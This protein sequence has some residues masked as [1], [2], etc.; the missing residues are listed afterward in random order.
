MK[1]GRI[2]EWFSIVI[3]KLDDHAQRNLVRVSAH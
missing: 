2:D 3:A 1:H